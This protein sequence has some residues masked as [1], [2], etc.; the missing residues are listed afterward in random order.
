[1]RYVCLLAILT[2]ILAASPSAPAQDALP[3]ALVNMDRV[4]KTHQPLLDKLAPIKVGVQDLEKKAQLRQIELETVVTQLRKAQPGTPESLR[5]QQQAAK[6]QTE[7]QQFVAKERDELQKREAAVFLEMYRQLEDEV[8]KYAKAN[9][10]KLVIRQ[11]DGSLDDKQPLQE[12]LKTLNRGIIYEEGLDITDE[13]L[14]ALDARTQ[15]E[16]KPAKQD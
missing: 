8:K 6:L 7:M 12:I 4:F 9:G 3:I 11:Q 5:L 2:A 10:I 15:S 16:A 14:K 13:I 1:M